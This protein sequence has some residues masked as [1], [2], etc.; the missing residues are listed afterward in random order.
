MKSRGY[1]CPIRTLI[2]FATQISCGP[3]SAHFPP[4]SFS[5]FG[6]QTWGQIE[7]PYADARIMRSFYALVQ[8]IHKNGTFSLSLV[9]LLPLWCT[10][11]PLEMSRDQGFVFA[12]TWACVHI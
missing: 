2:N 10:S 7:P 6:D 5:V 12:D 11:N 3:S 1:V 9:Y 4:D 8:V